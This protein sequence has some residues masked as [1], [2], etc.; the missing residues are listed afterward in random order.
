V[1]TYTETRDVGDAAATALRKRRSHFPPATQSQEIRFSSKRLSL[2]SR[3]VSTP[4]NLAFPGRSTQSALGGHRSRRIA[5][6]PAPV[7]RTEFQRLGHDGTSRWQEEAL[8]ELKLAK[9][10]MLSCRT[11]GPTSLYGVDYCSD[12]VGEH[13]DLNQAIESYEDKR[14]RAGSDFDSISLPRS[15][16]PIAP[17]LAIEQIQRSISRD[18]DEKEITIVKKPSSRS[19]RDPSPSFERSGPGKLDL[20]NAIETTHAV[21][22]PV[23]VAECMRS[24]IWADEK[25]FTG[26]QRLSIP[27]LL[28]DNAVKFTLSSR[29]LLSSAP[30]VDELAAILLEGR[31][32]RKGKDG[33]FYM[34]RQWIED[35]RN[36]KIILEHQGPRLGF[37]KILRP[38]SR[39]FDEKMITIAKKPSSPAL[40]DPSPCYDQSGLGKV[41]SNAIYATHAVLDAVEVAECIGN[42]VCA[43]DKSFKVCQ[44]LWLP[45]QIHEN[46]VNFTLSS[47]A[48]LSSGPSLDEL[49]AVLLAD[50]RDGKGK[51]GVFYMIRQWIEDVRS[52]K[53]VLGHPASR[54]DPNRS[55]Q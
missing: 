29:A 23:E 28:C 6:P 11:A 2:A 25:S 40:R 14:F 13:G 39:D 7:R 20:P 43:D 36:G 47:R 24:Y 52:G 48:L 51:D 46:A 21:L 54:I 10:N 37:K 8:N 16:R 42:F 22:D 33:V 31:I 1:Q 35:V 41:Q 5:S 17:S 4:R 26:P 49:A 30:S 19:L 9:A 12:D 32:D 50:R 18:F 27:I 15:S 45:G 3:S 44:R 38:T 34:I 53:I 55:T